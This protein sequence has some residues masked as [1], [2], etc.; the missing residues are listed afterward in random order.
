M[1]QAT[2]WGVGAEER[3][4]APRFDQVWVSAAPDQKWLAG[5]GVAALVVENGVAECRRLPPGDPRHLLLVG[6]FAYLPNRQGLSHMLALWP[7]LAAAGY[8]LTVVG[9]GSQGLFGPGLRGQGRV[10]DLLPYYQAAGIAVSPVRWGAGSPN[11][12]L[13]ALGFARPVVADP[14]GVGGLT[15][16]QRAAVEVA[17]TPGEWLSALER[18][19]D[20]A[21]YRQKAWQGSQAVELW[22]EAAGRALGCLPVGW[23][24][25][26]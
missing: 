2:L 20:P 21:C 22:G 8:R 24:D 3:R 26:P 14:G 4:W 7:G 25:P 13:E 1:K 5:R 19:Q 15:E 18:L 12:V 17:R 16:R 23:D 6:N 10:P 9:E 11:K